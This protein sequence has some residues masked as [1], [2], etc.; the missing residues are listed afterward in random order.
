LLEL[1]GSSAERVG[2]GGGVDGWG[3][4]A[5]AGPGAACRAT[6]STFRRR[7]LLLRAGRKEKCK[8][9]TTVTRNKTS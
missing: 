3:P 2:G 8:Y 4:G 7:A 6:S 9:R 1:A 5:T